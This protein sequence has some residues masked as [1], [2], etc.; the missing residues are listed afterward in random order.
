MPDPGADNSSCCS[1]T[2]ISI[3]RC[4]G[5]DRRTVG[6]LAQDFDV[7]HFMKRARKSRLGGKR[8]LI[9]GRRCRSRLSLNYRS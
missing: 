4:C 3:E 5:L 1:Q 2:M 6:R 9:A 8:C 7:P